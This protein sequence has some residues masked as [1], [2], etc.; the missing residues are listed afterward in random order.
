MKLITISGLD[1]SGKSTQV[2]LLEKKLKKK[3]FNIYRF[4]VISFSLANKILKPGK[5]NPGEAKSKTA[6][7]KRS[8][9]LRKISLLIDIFR[10]RHFY[11]MKNYR[12]KYDFILADRYFYDQIANIKFLENN[13]CKKIPLWQKIAEKYT[14]NPH[15]SIY[16]KITPE[17]ILKRDR[18]IEQGREYLLKKG[19]I[20][21]KFATRW[22]LR[23]L[24]ASQDKKTI[25]K[26]INEY[27]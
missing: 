15:Q 21:E 9:F 27:I 10:F 25:H 4:H 18:E 5:N 6:A 23:V 26:K 8:I 2:E 22:N 7:S 20:Y 12:K 16:L 13:A 11:L 19:K 17:E 3:G 1:G 24:D 14:V